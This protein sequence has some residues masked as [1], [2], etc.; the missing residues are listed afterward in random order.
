MT[1]TTIKHKTTKQ[2]ANEY[3]RDQI[4]KQLKH[5]TQQNKTI[6]KGQTYNHKKKRY[7]YNTITTISRNTNNIGQHKDTI[8][9]RTQYTTHT[10]IKHTHTN[11]NKTTKHK[12]KRKHILHNTTQTK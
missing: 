11:I 7:K 8:R 2:N 6:N 4:L 12:T 9:H 1:T 5:D 10:H 3:I